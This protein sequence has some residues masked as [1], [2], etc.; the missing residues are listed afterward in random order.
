MPP[1]NTL[2]TERRIDELEYKLQF[3]EDMID[4]L[5]QSLIVQQRDLLLMQEKL[6]MLAKQLE[7]NR[8]QQNIVEG[9][10]PPHY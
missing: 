8:Q 10:T 9:E 2:D 6:V 3:Q 1:M 7:A 5:N 4:S